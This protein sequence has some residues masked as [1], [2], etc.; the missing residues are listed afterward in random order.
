MRDLL[1]I[2]T[3]E[4]VYR[5]VV[6][7]GEEES[8]LFIPTVDHRVLFSVNIR[9]QA[10]IDLTDGI[11]VFRSEDNDSEVFV[12]LPPAEILLVDADES[13]I[14]QYFVRE[15]GGRVGWLEYG[16]QIEAIKGKN[17]EDAVERGIL[18]RAAENAR[19]VVRNFLE[20]AGF[21][22]VVFLPGA[23]TSNGTDG[24]AGPDGGELQ[25]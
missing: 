1:A 22:S 7:F 17:A 5:D 25:G 8:F 10:G 20:L 13:S 16:E 23:P 2:H 6:Y 19:M 3:M 24:E 21:E 4:H 9:V 14:H 11:E 15:R 12:R 18:V